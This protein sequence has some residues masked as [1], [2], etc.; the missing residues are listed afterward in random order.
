[1]RWSSGCTHSAS[2]RWAI[3]CP[4]RSRWPT[5]A[6]RLGTRLVTQPQALLLDEPFSAL[7][8]DLRQHLRQELEAVLDGAG[9]P[10]LLISHDPNDIEIFGARSPASKMGD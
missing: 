3:C 6:Y 5:P 4:R 2:T 9:I 8:H 10:L 1:M 7:D